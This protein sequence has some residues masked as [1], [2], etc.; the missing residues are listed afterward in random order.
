ME[1]D[2]KTR[3]AQAGVN[4]DSAMQRFMGNE[5]M[6]E[7]YLDRFLNEKSY[8]E[9]MTALG[10]DDKEGAARAAH[11][12][13]SVCGTLGFEKMQAQVIA[14]ESAIRNGQWEEAVKM[15]P[16][17]EEEYKHICSAISG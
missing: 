11:T 14:Q 1:A 10:S 4:L 16:E 9:L 15:I 3:L 5:K 8:Q 6:V 7:K 13:K 17:I 12:L 2:K